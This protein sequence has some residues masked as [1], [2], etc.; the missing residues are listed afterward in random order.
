[1]DQER[2][3]AILKLQVLDLRRRMTLVA[4]WHDTMHTPLHRKLWFWLQ[5]YNWA[6]LGTWYD[7]PWNRAN[8]QKYNGGI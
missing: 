8:G 4:A 2:E 5:G 6:S 1:M 7:A 3:I